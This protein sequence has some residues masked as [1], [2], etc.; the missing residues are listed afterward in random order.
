M[1]G[2]L[3]ALNIKKLAIMN[4]PYLFIFIIANR[5]SHL[6]QIS[7]GEK[8]GE[9][10][11][12]LMEH[13]DQVLG[14]IPSLQGKDLLVGIGVAVAA[15]LLIWQKQQDAKKFRKGVEYGSARWGDAE[16]I[17]PYMSDNPWMNI[18]LTATESLTMESRP[19]NPKYARNKNILVIGGSGSGKTR[20]FVKPSV[21]Q[22]NCS[23]VIT[24]PKG[25]LIGEVG[26]LLKR[27]A[28]K[29]DD[30]GRIIKGKDRNNLDVSTYTLK[31][32]A[33]MKL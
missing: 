26:K 14:V 5:I 1:K 3:S 24:D 29:R 10:I 4:L 15:K 11:M 27:G 25:T 6:Y 19:K 18:P 12:Y 9:K 2:K 16:D 22:L 17:K 32:K 33:Y 13:S 23:L 21:M 7:P 8:A 30:A 28:P 20:F 31:G